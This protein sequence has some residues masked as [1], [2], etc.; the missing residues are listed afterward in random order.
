MIDSK[1]PF[2]ILHIERLEFRVFHSPQPLQ[3]FDHLRVVFVLDRF[4]GGLVDGPTSVQF[5]HRSDVQSG[6]GRGLIDVIQIGVDAA[7]L[8]LEPHEVSEQ[9]FNASRS[10]EVDGIQERDFTVTNP[11]DNE[12]LNR[13]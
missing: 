9:L 8:V 4:S 2:S 5:Y 10:G 11:A 3:V 13:D 7:L 1:G 12:L 6:P